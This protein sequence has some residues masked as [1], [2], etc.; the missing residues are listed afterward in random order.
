MSDSGTVGAADGAADQAG[1][2][3]LDS[4][5]G[6]SILAMAILGSAVAMLTSTV[7]GVALPT[8][9]AEFDATSAQ[10]TWVINAYALPLAALILIGGSLGDRSG[11]LRVYR[12]GIV[13]FAVASLLCAVAWNVESLIAFRIL[14]GIGGALLTPGSLAIIQVTLR[15]EDRGRG[16]GAWSGLGGIASAVGPLV[17]GLLVDASWR[18]AFLINVPVAVAAL[19]LSARVPETRDETAQDTRL[20]GAGAALTVL[21]LGGLSYALI[22]GPNDGWSSLDIAAG[23]IGVVAIPVL[24]RIERGRDHAMLPVDLFADRTFSVVN[25]LTFTVYGGMGVVFFLLPL[26][27]QVTAGWSPVGAGAALLPVTVMMLLF[28]ARAG[29]MATRI[30]PRLPLTIGPL[31]VAA[32][33]LLMLRVDASASYVADV[34]PAALV[35]GAG[36]AVMVAP[37]TATA[38]GAAPSERAGA[39]SGVNNAVSRTGGLLLVAAVPSLV[40]LTGTALSDPLALDE[41]FGRAVVVSVVVVAGSALIAFALLPR[42]V[43]ESADEQDELTVVCS[44]CP[45]DGNVATVVGAA[46]ES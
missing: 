35:Y 5:R 45:V 3:R 19:L 1:S 37:L 40:G 23:V 6:R 4:S 32:G 26:Q 34:L 16:V 17:G 29:E 14:Q 24:L 27:L 25:S 21:M 39:A 36:L 38:L 8:I 7:V 30:G 31:I 43:D 46:A 20:D 42:R 44:R 10:Q 12:I 15:A 41:G 9:A 13:W 28:S 18:W 22:E 2:I 33:M 11:R